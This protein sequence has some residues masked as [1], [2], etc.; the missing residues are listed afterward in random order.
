MIEI[1]YILFSKCSYWVEVSSDKTGDLGNLSDT[2]ED[3]YR[4]NSC[5]NSFRMGERN[6]G[7]NETLK[8]YLTIG[9]RNLKKEEKN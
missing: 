9:S 4:G 1:S 7:H 5:E 3:K 2:V 6:G 8:L